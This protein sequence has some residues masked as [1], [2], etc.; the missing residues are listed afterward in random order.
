MKRNEYDHLINRLAQL[1]SEQVK[2]TTI[3]EWKPSYLTDERESK[4]EKVLD[5]TNSEICKV[6]NALD[7]CINSDDVDSFIPHFE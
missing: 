7:N 5:L 3:L 2:Y 6:M 4:Y 1:K